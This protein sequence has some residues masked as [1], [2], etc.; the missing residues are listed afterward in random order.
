MN[1]DTAQTNGVRE[2]HVDET[3]TTAANPRRTPAKN[4]GF[5]GASLGGDKNYYLNQQVE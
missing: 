2:I 1:V 4:P 3:R 5:A